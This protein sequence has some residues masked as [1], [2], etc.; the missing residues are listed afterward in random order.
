MCGGSSNYL[1]PG[2]IVRNVSVF[3]A[4]RHNGWLY[5]PIEEAGVSCRV[6]DGISGF[7]RGPRGRTGL[8]QTTG[9][10]N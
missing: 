6:K 3:V 1:Q 9:F 7:T 2:G 5:V 4:S 10:D 8:E